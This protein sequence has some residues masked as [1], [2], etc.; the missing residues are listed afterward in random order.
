MGVHG[1][2]AD[3]RT[4]RD[5]GTSAERVL[6]AVGGGLLATAPY[7]P[8]VRIVLLGGF[9]LPALLSATQTLTLLAY[10]ATAAGVAV[11]L[12]AALSRSMGPVRVTALVVGCVAGVGGGF[13]VTELIEA[14]SGS[15]GIAELGIGSILAMIG[16]ALLI[17]PPLVGNA[18]A[19]GLRA[20][21]LWWAP[22]VACVALALIVAWVPVHTDTGAYCGTPI[23]AL[24]KS[25]VPVPSETPPSDVAA[26]LESDQAAVQAAESAQ[27]TQQQTDSQ[28]QQAQ[29]NADQLSTEAQQ[30]DDT[31]SAASSTV[32][33]DQGTVDGDQ[34]DVQ[35]GQ[36]TVASD[37][38]T[39]QSDQQLLASDKQ[40]GFDTTTDQQAI[41]S[42]N[43]TLAT[44]QQALQAAEAK[45]AQDQ[46]TL[47]ADTAAAAAAQ[48]KATKL[49]QAAQA[50]E[51]Q[52]STQGDQTATS[53]STV[54][55]NL[56]AAKQQLADDQQ[57]WQTIHDAQV[58]AAT[59][60]NTTLDRCQTQATDQLAVAAVLA[61]IGVLLS[62]AML[63]RR[64][65]RMDAQTQQW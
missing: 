24:F 55:Q 58:S 12:V 46:V 3:P 29:A 51:Q 54:A 7:L 34:G 37:Q 63:A 52:A 40:N 45:L 48:Q 53:D 41:A 38:Q 14:V 5:A 60:Y 44:D 61:A 20:A 19:G 59:A 23:G 10:V 25:S 11:V 36:A 28:A 65:R 6:I 27:A 64:G 43:Q 1:M 15:H 57:E 4:P 22:A 42:D 31:A 62:G 16:C 33:T 35:G 2:F 50:A 39:L 49:D 56:D 21:S 26:K 9:D 8:W 17:V 18:R 30:A 47:Q 32:D 13:L